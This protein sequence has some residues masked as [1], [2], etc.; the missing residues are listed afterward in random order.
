MHSLRTNLNKTTQQ[1]LIKNPTFSFYMFLE[2]IHTKRSNLNYYRIFQFSSKIKFIFSNNQN[3]H[4]TIH[5]LHDHDQI[6]KFWYLSRSSQLMQ[7]EQCWARPSRPIILVGL[8]VRPFLIILFEPLSFFIFLTTTFSL[9]NLFHSV[10]N[11]PNFNLFFSK[12]IWMP[13]SCSFFFFRP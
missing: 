12:S 3:N 8:L 13:C 10:L 1:N 9:S 4:Q 5:N 2:V 7:V 6:S 11:L